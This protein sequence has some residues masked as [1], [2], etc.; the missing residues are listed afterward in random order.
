MNN[1]IKEAHRRSLWQVTGIYLAASWIA[2]QVVQTLTEAAG[3]PDWTPGMALVLLV[4]G[5]PITLG[6]AFVQEGMPGN[7]GQVDDSGRQP[8]KVDHDDRD[9]GLTE[10]SSGSTGN[11][12]KL[13]FLTWRNVVFGGIGAFAL[14]GF[15]LVAYF[16]LWSTGLGPQGSLVA[17]GVIE[18]GD[19]IVLAEF[20]DLTGE[21]LGDVTTDAIRV[22]L[23][24]ST[25]IT[26]ASPSYVRSVLRR[27]GRPETDIL[28]SQIA[29]ELAQ[30]EGMKAI[31]T[32]EVSSVGSGY[33]LT[34]ALVAAESG[35]VIR[36]FRVSVSSQDDLLGGIDKLSQ[37]IREKTGESLGSIKQGTSLAE[38]TTTSLEALRLLAR[39]DELR[40]S[41]QQAEAVPLLERALELDQD[42]AMAW[43]ML[44]VLLRNTGVDQ[45]RAIMAASRAF[46]LR[47]R[48]TDREAAQAEAYYR[49]T[50]EGDFS[51]AVS[52]YQRLLDRHPDDGT[53]LNNIGV[54]LQTQRRFSQA[55]PYLQRA[56]ARPSPSQS[57]FAMLI[58][59][60]WGSGNLE[61]AWAALEGLEMLGTDVGLFRRHQLLAASGR[62]E[63]A[64]EVA[65]Q[66]L[67]A[68]PTLTPQ[69]TTR[70]LIASYSLAL[71]QYS[72]ALDLLSDA[73]RIAFSF[74]APGLYLHTAGKLRLALAALHE[75]P[76]TR[77]QTL[78]TVLEG[79]EASDFNL[80][81]RESRGVLGAVVMAG[82]L[83]TAREAFEHW[84]EAVPV[85]RQGVQ[86][87]M[88]EAELRIFGAL[89][90]G[91]RERA[92]SLFSELH[93]EIS[94]CEA[95]CVWAEE[96]G[97]IED[98][99]GNIEAVLDMYQ[100]HLSAGGFVPESTVW[101]PMVLE[102]LADL[103]L[104][105]ADTVT[106]RSH[107]E[108][109]VTTYEGGNG[110]FPAYASRARAS[111]A[112]LN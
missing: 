38:A 52:V 101:T 73:R 34:A 71:G 33:L 22:D 63:D 77:Q 9:I 49:Y 6:T 18:E 82:G 48:L 109:L 90:N 94:A 78:E 93:E 41:G 28:T 3:L 74:E 14:L 100:G 92:A 112:S 40:N 97:R 110:P 32:G 12:R 98:E 66:E 39:A 20:D 108:R 27:M 105:R 106:A 1:F 24:E 104:G 25:V 76:A 50:V 46:E 11:G 58:Q 65:R 13:R 111:L 69:V 72:E 88:H 19:M 35:D 68:R 62:W 96:R 54:M 36:A 79:V 55:V 42:F 23:Q 45:E 87:R 85:A 31:V 47:H 83:E 29:R 4:L 44:A 30:R 86:Y 102:R 84:L 17:Q 80:S 75:D 60:L 57:S 56:T 15:S 10:M 7:E 99:L 21:R 16:L 103:S 95:F 59:A 81:R 70:S 8:S 2:L 107:L 91:D 89:A 26:V 64:I 5:M 43:R 61:S 67:E 51:A 53:A 37:D